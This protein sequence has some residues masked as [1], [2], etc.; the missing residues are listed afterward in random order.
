MQFQAELSTDRM[1]ERENHSSSLLQ[2]PAPDPAMS[3]AVR[4][5]A[6]HSVGRLRDPQ[7]EDIP[8]QRTLLP[9][10]QTPVANSRAI[11]PIR[12]L[13]LA[14]RPLRP[15]MTTHGLQMDQ[16]VELLSAQP[17][18]SQPLGLTRDP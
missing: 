8:M 4:R 11:I 16:D 15:A 18:G 2:F 5:A 1:S 17:I 9:V 13:L 10:R 7:S 14:H 12:R 3:F 6:G